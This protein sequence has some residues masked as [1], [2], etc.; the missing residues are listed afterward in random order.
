MLPK[1][2]KKEIYIKFQGRKTNDSKCAHKWVIMF[3]ANLANNG[4][5]CSLLF[6]K[7]VLFVVFDVDTSVNA[8]GVRFRI[9]LR[10][11]NINP[12]EI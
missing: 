11:E 3:F 7:T 8:N 6:F 12:I 2:W 9:H 5:R 1:N 4:R 10:L